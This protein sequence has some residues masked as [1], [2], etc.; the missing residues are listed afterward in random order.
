MREVILQPV[1]CSLVSW[2]S[3]ALLNSLNRS[4][5]SQ[6]QDEVFC[7]RYLAGDGSVCHPDAG[8][9]SSRFPDSLVERCSYK[10]FPA[11]NSLRLN[12]KESTGIPDCQGRL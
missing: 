9:V 11:R 2:F 8:P 1:S 10:N 6:C 5:Y 4:S 7:G 12:S 3:G